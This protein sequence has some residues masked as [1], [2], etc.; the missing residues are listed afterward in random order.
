MNWKLILQLSLFGLFMGVATVFFIPSTIEPVCWLAIF[1]ISAWGIVKRA[2]RRPF[3][4]GVLVGLANSVWVT[5]AHV[6]LFGS[7]VARHPREMAMMA[8]GPLP[9]HPRIM[10]LGTGPLIGLVSGMLIGLIALVAWRVTGRGTGTERPDRVDRDG[11]EVG[12]VESGAPAPS[13]YRVPDFP[14]RRNQPRG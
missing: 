13:D 11:Q 8:N 14:E 7:Y 5:G 12:R 9:T 1:A 6:L 3:G 2:P 4:H 10:M